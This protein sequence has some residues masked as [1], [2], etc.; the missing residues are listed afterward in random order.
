MVPD[1]QTEPHIVAGRLI[2]LVPGTP[3]DVALHWQ[4]NRLTAAALAPLTR[5]LR[6]AARGLQT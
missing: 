1:Q 4:F 2:E 6:R 3:L 5:A